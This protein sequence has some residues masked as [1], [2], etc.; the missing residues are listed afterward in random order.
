MTAR[1]GHPAQVIG[2]VGPAFDSDGSSNPPEF[3]R[4]WEPYD[5]EEGGWINTITKEWRP[6]KPPDAD[7]PARNERG[8]FTR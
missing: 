1:G 3:Q 7:L 5:G 4:L 8:Q 6:D 2:K